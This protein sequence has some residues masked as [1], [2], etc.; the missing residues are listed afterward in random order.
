MLPSNSNN[1]IRIR[2]YYQVHTTTN[3]IPPPR[4]VLIANSIHFADIAQTAVHSSMII[5]IVVVV[6]NITTFIYYKK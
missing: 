3:G 4:A 6:H 1:S 5:D 2:L